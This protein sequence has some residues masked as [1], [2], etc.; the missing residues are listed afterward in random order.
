MLLEDVSR[1]IKY[2]ISNPVSIYPIQLPNVSL[3]QPQLGSRGWWST[4]QEYKLEEEMIEKKT[5]Y[6]LRRKFLHVK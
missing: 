6:I 4:L 1:D 3:K 2:F 5:I